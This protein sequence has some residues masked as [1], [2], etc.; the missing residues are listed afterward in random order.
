MLR[1]LRVLAS[2]FLVA[3]FG[4]STNTATGRAVTSWFPR[5]ERGFALGIRQTSIPLGG[6]T[7]AF[8]VPPIVDHWGSRGA[9]LVLAGFS[10]AA[11]LAAVATM[12]EGPIKAVTCRSGIS[13]VMPWSTLAGP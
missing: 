13:R 10:L 9:L 4:A 8:G 7:A 2:L 1:L 3:A 5:A 11:A 12:A 6:F